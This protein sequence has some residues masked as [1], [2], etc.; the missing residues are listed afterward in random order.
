MT[1]NSAGFGKCRP[2]NSRDIQTFID[3]VRD[4]AIRIEEMLNNMGYHKLL[5]RNYYILVHYI[6]RQ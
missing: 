1:S 6:E 3:L 4:E 2:K 5:F